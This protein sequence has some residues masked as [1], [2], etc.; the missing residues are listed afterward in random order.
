MKKAIL[1]LPILALAMLSLAAKDRFLA[2][3]HLSADFS[4][5]QNYW[6]V[7]GKIQPGLDLRIGWNFYNRF[8][9]WSGLGLTPG[10]G[11]IPEVDASAFSWQLRLQLGV[12]YRFRLYR[13]AQLFLHAGLAPTFYGESAMEASE[14]DSAI[15]AEGGIDLQ[16]PLKNKSFFSIM[17][18]IVFAQDARGGREYFP[19]SLRLGFGLG[20][21][22]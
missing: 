10:F 21:T 1:C 6:E 16:L 22:F 8:F 11:K 14:S 20:K 17:L 3:G 18:D 13:R 5:D 15:G 2:A 9:L 4:L 7:Y 12:G 19:G